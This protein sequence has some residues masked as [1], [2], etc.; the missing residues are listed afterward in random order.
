M[1]ACLLTSVLCVLVSLS[2]SRRCH[3]LCP[4]WACA[5]VV[6]FVLP[7]VCL[8][9]TTC[10]IH[11]HGVV[12]LGID[13]SLLRVMLICSPCLPCATRLAFF[14]SMLSCCTLTYMFMHEFVSSILQ[15]NGAMDTPSK[16]TFVLLGHPLCSIACLFALSYASLP[17]SCALHIC[18]PL[19]GIFASLFFACFP[20][21]L[22]LLL[23]LFAD[24]FLWSLHVHTWGEDAW[25]KVTT[26]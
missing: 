10:E 2:R 15:S 9:V 22:C 5:C 25:S 19:F 14:A 21:L 3:A 20:Y 8:Y 23:C 17:F 24:L 6:A 4:L 1:F 12:V 13:L 16:P 7:R 11:I 18:L 26:S